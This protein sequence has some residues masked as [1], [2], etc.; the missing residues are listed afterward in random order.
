M[1][2]KVNHVFDFYKKIEMPL[3]F[4]L[5]IVLVVAILNVQHI[6]DALKSYGPNPV[7]RVLA[8]A[9]VLGI[10]HLISPLHAFLAALFVALYIS[11]TPGYNTEGYEDTQYM[12]SKKKKW[13]DE[14][15][16]SENPILIQSDRAITQAPNT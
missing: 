2:P 16:L 14:K 4:I 3:H 11:F 6:P 7:Y 1:A 15:V 8:F 10:G 12:D 5:Y 9:T 13:Y